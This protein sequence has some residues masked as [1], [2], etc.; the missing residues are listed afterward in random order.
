MTKT[1]WSFNVQFETLESGSQVKSRRW[2]SLLWSVTSLREITNAR[3]GHLLSESTLI[4]DIAFL[5]ECVLVDSANQ[6]GDRTVWSRILCEW[7]RLECHTGRILHRLSLDNQLFWKSGKE[8]VIQLALLL[9]MAHFVP[10]I[11]VWRLLW[12]VTFRKYFMIWWNGGKGDDEPRLIRQPFLVLYLDDFRRAVLDRNSMID[13]PNQGMSGRRS[14]TWLEDQVSIHRA[15]HLSSK[16]L[17][18]HRLG[19]PWQR[20]IC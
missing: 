5:L 13:H 15:P 1:S 7:L 4:G 10:C 8:F 14:W 11:L 12:V 18:N 3:R 6:F 17:E 19:Q 9:E 20:D 16:Q 2:S